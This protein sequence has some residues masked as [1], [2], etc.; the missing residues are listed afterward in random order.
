MMRNLIISV[1]VC[2]LLGGC[3]VSVPDA[4]HVVDEAPS[5][6]PDYIGVTVPSNI[7]PLRFMLKGEA[8]G[9]VAVLNTSDYELVEEAKDGQFLFSQKE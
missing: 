7:A 4:Q 3:S 6:Y 9:V 1:C 5:I 8:E 2:A